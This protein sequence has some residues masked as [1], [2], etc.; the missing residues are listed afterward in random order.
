MRIVLDEVKK[1]NVDGAYCNYDINPKN[2][3]ELISVDEL[4]QHTVDDVLK[5][6]FRPYIGLTYT[7]ICDKLGINPITAKSKYFVIAN[8]IASHNKIGNVNTSEEFVKN[9]A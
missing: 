4:R 5:E 7:D 8:A 6:R 3:E 9:Q 2:L 1:N